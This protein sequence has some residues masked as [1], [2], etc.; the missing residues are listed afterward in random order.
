MA[1]LIAW[2][3]MFVLHCLYKHFALRFYP[4]QACRGQ[5]QKIKGVVSEMGKIISKKSDEA[6]IAN[7]E[8]KL[9]TAA[10]LALLP[11]LA[12]QLFPHLTESVPSH[13]MWASW[14]H[15]QSRALE[16][17]ETSLT[18]NLG[19]GRALN[20]ALIRITR[21]SNKDPCGLS[22]KSR[23]GCTMPYNTCVINRC[24]KL[25]TG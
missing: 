21:L 9:N 22:S 6:Q 8:N 7:L 11:D 15:L 20:G 19:T 4:D 24:S 1:D 5:V 14:Y 17:R 16:D 13:V 10:C 3:L 18:I 25:A 2:C 12:E 23:C